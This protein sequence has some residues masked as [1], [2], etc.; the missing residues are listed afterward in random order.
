MKISAFHQWI[1]VSLI[2]TIMVAI[3]ASINF[4]TPI[5][6]DYWAPRVFGQEQGPSLIESIKGYIRGFTAGNPRIGQFW[7]V[8]GGYFPFLYEIIAS[9]FAVLYVYLMGI[10][11]YGKQFLRHP[12]IALAIGIV[13]LSLLWFIDREIAPIFFYEPANSNYLFAALLL[14]AFILPYYLSWGE[15]DGEKSNISKFAVTSFIILS[16]LAGMA[17]ETYGP[18]VIGLLGFFLVSGRWLNMQIEKWMWIGWVAFLIGYL[19]IFSAPGQDKRYSENRFEGLIQNFSQLDII[20]PRI[21][22]YYVGNGGLLILLALSVLVIR[23]ASKQIKLKRGYSLLSLFLIG[24]GTMITAVAA[25]IFGERLAFMAHTTMAIVITAAFFSDFKQAKFKWGAISLATFIATGY[26]VSE[27]RSTHS[28]YAMYRAQFDTQAAV[29]E[30]AKNRGE[31]KVSVPAYSVPFYS[32]KKYLFP[33]FPQHGPSAR[34][35]KI[36]ARY[37][38]VDSIK[39]VPSKEII[40]YGKRFLSQPNE[41]KLVDCPLS[42]EESWQ[43]KKDYMGTLVC[44]KRYKIYFDAITSEWVVS[45]P[46][47]VPAKTFSLKNVTYRT[48]GNGPETGRLRIWGGDYRFNDLGAIVTDKGQRIGQIKN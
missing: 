8:F 26:L 9:I 7:L 1:F 29:I 15:P 44:G 28:A 23:M 35:N 19:L 6:G 10:Y 42:D 20:I 12:S 30:N 25:P 5:A 16:L 11:V 43:D 47:E 40:D 22:D 18:P 24:I 27:Y 38:G 13:A 41:F 46:R 37:Y 45:G 39:M 17:H 3:F 34:V 36:I 2:S 33:E 21:F 4:I 14:L 31:T 48:K 32:L